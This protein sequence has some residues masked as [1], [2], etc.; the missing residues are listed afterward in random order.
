MPADCIFCRIVAG[1]IP[2]TKVYEDEHVIA[3]HD[4][5]PQAPVHLLFIPKQHV[6]GVNDLQGNQFNLIGSMF[7]AMKQVASEEG[8]AETGYRIITNNGKD[9]GQVVFHLHFHLLGGKMLGPLG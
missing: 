1:E 2:A 8:L 7:A 5:Q 6:A 9:S 3:F 4:I